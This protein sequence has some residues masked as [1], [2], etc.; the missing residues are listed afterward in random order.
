MYS[1]MDHQQ[2]RHQLRAKFI[3]E[4]D[5]KTTLEDIGESLDEI[6]LD[7]K[8]R[9]GQYYHGS[10]HFSEQPEI[11]THNTGSKNFDWKGRL[12]DEL[13]TTE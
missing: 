13:D 3:E 12:Y 1:Y 8:A 7:S 9:Y 11:A 4:M 5:K 2:H 6:I 10:R